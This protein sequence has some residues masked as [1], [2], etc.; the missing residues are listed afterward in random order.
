MVTVMLRNALAALAVITLL[1]SGA[2]AAGNHLGWCI[3]T[4]NPHSAPNC[5]GTEPPTGALS[6]TVPTVNQLPTGGAQTGPT[7]PQSPA[8]ITVVP[9]PPTTFTGTGQV[10]AVAGQPGTPITGT[11]LPPIVVRPVDPT[12]ITGVG[13]VPTLQA[14]PTP[15]FTGQGQLP[16][17]IQPL[18]PQVL[19]GTAPTVAPTAVSAPSFT[20]QGLPTI[21]VVPNPPVTV[22]GFGP[23][24]ATII[25]HGSP[26]PSFTGSNPVP[27]LQPM[28]IPGQVPTATPVAIPPATPSRVGVIV[29][30]SA[31]PQQVPTRIPSAIPRPRPIKHPGRIP[32]GTVAP[33]VNQAVPLTAAVGPNLVTGQTGRQDA[34]AAPQFAAP[35][36]NGK[37]TCLASG[38][39]KRR[40]VVDGEVATTGAL[41]HVGAVDVLGRDLPALHPERSGCI[42]SVRRRKE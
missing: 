28:A 25:V 29:V 24:P 26:G 5:G 35:G 18:P 37:W 21:I 15:S 30:P 31:Q 23:L 6:P 13:P 9:N 14:T 39:G 40:S 7:P 38:H 36:G 27:P 41:M 32:G 34:H 11:G 2:N 17:V 19:T 10:P 1:P 12:V 3:G 22:T 4:N 42:I 16:I 8:I 20:G 33:I